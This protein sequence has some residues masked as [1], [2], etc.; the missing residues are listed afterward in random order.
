MQ[1][2]INLVVNFAL[3]FTLSYSANGYADDNFNQSGIVEGVVSE[4]DI[5][6]NTFTVVEKITG[7]KETF[8]LPE[9]TRITVEGESYRDLSLIKLGQT[10]TFRV[11]Q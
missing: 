6:N 9:N 5:E 3:I 11:K 8:N 2:F 10:I 7:N 1:T 4:I